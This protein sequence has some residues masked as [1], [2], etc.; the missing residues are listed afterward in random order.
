MNK[1]Y[2]VRH[3]P[4]KNYFD[5][6]TEG[7]D[8]PIDEAG[9]EIEPDAKRKVTRK[10][11]RREYAFVWWAYPIPVRVKVQWKNSNGE[12]ESRTEEH[13]YGIEASSAEEALEFR[14]GAKA[15]TGQS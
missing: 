10:R 15:W 8:F 6:H 12:I 11:G 3:Y 4:A 7:G 5:R 14:V 9:N 1:Q 2:V 13:T